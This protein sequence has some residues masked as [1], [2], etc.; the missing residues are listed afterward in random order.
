MTGDW[1]FD[2]VVTTRVKVPLLGEAVIETHKVM[3]ARVE[4]QADGRVQQ[5][6]TACAMYARSTRKIAQASFPPSFVAAMHDQSYD[7]S[8]QPEG[9]GWRLRAEVEPVHLGWDPKLTGGVM[10]RHKDA[11]GVID[12][13]HDGKP[14]VTIFVKAPIFGQVEVY[15]VQLSE[16]WIDGLLQGDD[17]VT[18]RARLAALDQQTI[19][20]SNPLFISNVPITPD[21]DMS[22]FR[23]ARL[24]AGTT[25]QSLDAVSPPLAGTPAADRSEH[26]AAA[27]H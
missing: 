25:C 2:V 16:T 23:M 1:R 8:V 13:D 21:D 26:G 9:A 22:W 17:L 24:P 14:G 19:G 20:A 3:L 12:A 5:S 15:V 18:G 6:H 10:P 7:I 27:T 11:P 4:T